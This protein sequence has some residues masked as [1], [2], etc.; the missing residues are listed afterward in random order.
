[1]HGPGVRSEGLR[2]D[3]TVSMVPGKRDGA[4]GGVSSETKVPEPRRRFA[5][6]SRAGG[7][8]GIVS[9]KVSA[10]SAVSSHAW[11]SKARGEVVENQ[12]V[13]DMTRAFLGAFKNIVWRRDS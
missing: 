8:A 10:P 7:Q 13:V 9:E 3:N 12:Q 4:A 5:A 6:K 2:K 11:Q 1:M